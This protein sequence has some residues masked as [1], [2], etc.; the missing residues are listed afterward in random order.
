MAMVVTD[1]GCDDILN[2]YLNDVRSDNGNGLDLS[3][4]LYTNDY[5]ANGTSNNTNFTE[6]AGG[7]YAAITLSSNNWTVTPANDPSDAVYNNQTYTF[8]GN[9]TGNTTVYGYFV[10]NA[11]NVVIWAERFNNSFT[12]TNNGDSITI[13]PKIEMSNGTPA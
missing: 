10:T 7:N 12:P 5:T 2:V 13:Q 4:R 8:N 11:D 1:I 9:L 6:A 3:L